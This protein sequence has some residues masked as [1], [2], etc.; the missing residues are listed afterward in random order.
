MAGVFFNPTQIMASR[1]MSLSRSPFNPDI[2]IIKRASF[3]K[4]ETPA[5]LV[6]FAIRS[7]ECKG[8]NGTGVYKGKLVPQTAICVAEKHGGARAARPRRARVTA[9]AA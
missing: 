7:G 6:G 4:G 8:R 1:T 9:P 3:P 2:V 5:H